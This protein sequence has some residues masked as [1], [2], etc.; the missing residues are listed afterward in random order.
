MALSDQTKKDFIR[1]HSDLSDEELARQTGWNIQRIQRFKERLKE[2]S[3]PVNHPVPGGGPLASL[4]T[5]SWGL[6]AL[7]PTLLFYLPALSCDFLNWDDPDL[8][9]DNAHLSYLNG[10]FLHWAFTTFK[11]G[12]W[13]PMVWLSLALDYRIGGP[14]S[15]VFHL[16]NLLIHGLNTLLVFWLSIQIFLVW[17]NTKG[18]PQ[19]GEK[20]GWQAPSA[21]LAALLFGLHPLHVES[22]AW[23]IERK[24]VLYGA[25]FLSSLCAYLAYAA[26]SRWKPLKYALSLLLFAASLA[27]KPMAMTLP[28]VLVLLD[29]WPLQRWAREKGK[30]LFEK[31]PF[32][33]GSLAVGLVTLKTLAQA[34]TL[35]NVAKLPPDL[36]VLNAFHSIFFYL[37]KM[38]LPWNLAAYYPLPYPAQAYSVGYLGSAAGVLLILAFGWHYRRSKPYLTWALVYYLITLAPVLGLVQPGSQ[39]AADRFTYLPLLG[40]FLVFSAWL[41]SRFWR[42]KWPEI[43]AMA[44]LALAL[45]LL[46]VRQLGFW[47]N[48]VVLWENARRVDA[49][50]TEL[51]YS[52]LGNAYYAAHRLPDALENFDKAIA[53]GPPESNPHEGKAIVLYDMGR[54]QDALEE[55]QTAISLNPGKLAI[56]QQLWIAY[57]RMGRQYEKALAEAQEMIRL[58]P[59]F[60]DGYD[61]LAATYASKGLF[62]QSIEASKKALELYA[63]SPKYLVRLATTYQEAGRYGEAIETFERALALQPDNQEIQ[64]KLALA[65][66]LNARGRENKKP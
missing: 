6:T 1:Q 65:N 8:I 34:N 63:S 19:A 62:N 36:R 2:V 13:M 37:V 3:K 52:N 47:R 60:P 42:G 33:L 9:V 7:I 64:Q 54:V 23:A 59:D 18:T 14:G 27:S 53:L 57:S 26:S 51:V 41:G 11:G 35:T 15:Y 29:L 38:V 44:A 48:S 40:F 30:A 45:G 21:C 39:G 25:F 17:D 66:Q 16:D 4:R 31:I 5:W 20:Q 55:F 56:H 24:D 61:K 32:F 46:T 43:L 58:A 22:V 49:Y 28:V 12:Y 50:E 10:D